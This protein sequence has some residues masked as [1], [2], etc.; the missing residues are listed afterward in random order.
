MG[1][2]YVIHC[3]D[4]RYCSVRDISGFRIFDVINYYEFDLVKFRKALR[5]RHVGN[6]PGDMMAFLARTPGAE[7]ASGRV[8]EF[9]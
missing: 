4:Q 9:A 3:G 5:V 8:G 7:L 2:F 1:A 6:S